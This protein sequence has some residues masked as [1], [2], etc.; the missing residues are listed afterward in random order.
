MC[1][2][3]RFLG[4]A[5]PGQRLQ[6][7]QQFQERERLDQVVVGAVVQAADAVLDAVARGQHDDRRLAHAA[8]GPQHREAVHARQHRVQHDHVVIVLQRQVLARCV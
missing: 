8:Q 3:D 4:A 5:A 1:I 2:R 6:P 7:R